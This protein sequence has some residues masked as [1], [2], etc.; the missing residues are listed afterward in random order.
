MSAYREVELRCDGIPDDPYG[1]DPAIYARNARLA[2]RYARSRGWATN[3]PGG[4]D[5]CPTHRAQAENR[6][7]GGPDVSQTPEAARLT[8]RIELLQAA[9]AELDHHFSP[10]T[11]RWIHA[12][13]VTRQ[14][15]LELVRDLATGARFQ[16][17]ALTRARDGIGKPS[18]H[19]DGGS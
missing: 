10:F 7:G 19:G 1:C 8:R 11:V 17:T 12:N 13:N 3:L 16:V 18:A 9:T 15:W 5:L 4:R 2:R 6:A 14:E